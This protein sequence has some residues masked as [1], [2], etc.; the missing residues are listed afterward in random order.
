MMAPPDNMQA[1][2][3]GYHLRLKELLQAL[4]TAQQAQTSPPGRPFG[5][6]AETYC[7]ICMQ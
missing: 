1:L 6:C 5:K 4:F 3:E 7:F 2:W